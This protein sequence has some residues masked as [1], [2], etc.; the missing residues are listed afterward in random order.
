MRLQQ[1]RVRPMQE[2]QI[3]YFSGQGRSLGQHEILRKQD[4]YSFFLGPP[5]TKYLQ[6]EKSD[7]PVQAEA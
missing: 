2:S 7:H 3:L 5:V 1:E 6:L 4:S